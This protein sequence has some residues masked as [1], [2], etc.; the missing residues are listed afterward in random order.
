VT[1]LP[2]P[3]GEPGAPRGDRAGELRAAAERLDRRIAAACAAAGRPRAD[4]TTVA[5]TKTF[6]ASDVEAWYLATGLVD[7]GE[8]R[9]QELRAKRA[10]LA[11]LPVRWHFL[12]RLQANKARAVGRSAD[13]VHSV[14]RDALLPL[15]SRGAAERDAPL[16]VFVQVSLDGDPA[17]AGVPPAELHRLADAVAATAALTLRGLMAVAPRGAEPAAA[18]G[19]LA[20]LAA[21]VRERHPHARDLSAGMSGDLEAAVAHGATHLRVGSALFGVRPPLDR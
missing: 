6:P 19:Q 17:R 18:F 12:G 15:L 21:A 13:V 16:G 5:V 10:A 11:G 8:A 14:D 20:E 9:E 3:D 2:S 7:V 4:V 1:A